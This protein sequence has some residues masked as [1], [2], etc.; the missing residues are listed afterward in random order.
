MSK[1]KHSDDLCE[2]YLCGKQSPKIKP[3]FIDFSL[4][5]EQFHG[6]WELCKKCLKKSVRELRKIVDKLD[7]LEDK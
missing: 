1:E 6:R 7:G 5:G 2:C 3:L 4:D